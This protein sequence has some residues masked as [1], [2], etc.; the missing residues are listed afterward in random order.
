MRLKKQS[1]HLEFVDRT[2]RF[3][4]PLDVTILNQTEVKHYHLLVVLFGNPFI[5]AMESKT[6]KKKE[7]KEMFMLPEKNKFFNFY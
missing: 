2:V 1:R 5:D 3:R 7:K 4:E 6:K